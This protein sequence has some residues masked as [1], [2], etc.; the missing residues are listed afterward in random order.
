MTPCWARDSAGRAW[1]TLCQKLKKRPENEG[2]TGASWT[3]LLLPKSDVM[4][5]SKYVMTAM[6][7]SPLNKVRICDSIPR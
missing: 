2:G 7:P 3:E 6:D 5:T 1:N 4:G